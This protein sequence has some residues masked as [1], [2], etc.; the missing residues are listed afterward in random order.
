MKKKI[1]IASPYTIGDHL[2]NVN[3]QMDMYYDLV[4]LG[5]LPFAPLYSHYIHERN[6]LPYDIW[7]EIDYAWIDSC[8]CLLRLPGESNGADLEV[9]YAEEKGMPIFYSVEELTNYIE[10]KPDFNEGDIH[11]SC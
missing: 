1:Y 5:Y 6:P 10:E 7:M 9:K 11:I 4:Q 8:D 3:V 2:E